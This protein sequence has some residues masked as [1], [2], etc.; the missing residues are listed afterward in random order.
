MN[1]TQSQIQSRRMQKI[2]NYVLNTKV[3]FQLNCSLNP[4]ERYGRETMKLAYNDDTNF[5][6]ITTLQEMKLYRKIDDIIISKVSDPD[7]VYQNKMRI[8]VMRTRNEYDDIVE[9]LCVLNGRILYNDVL[10]T[11]CKR[12]Y[13]LT[14]NVY[15]AVYRDYVEANERN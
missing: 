15:D 8:F 4:Y 14:Y 3:A 11:T 2:V 6:I 9:R 13:D 10:E 12:L 5:E 1:Q 7:L